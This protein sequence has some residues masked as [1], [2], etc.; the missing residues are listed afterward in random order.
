MLAG[1]TDYG[2]DRETAGPPVT[3]AQAVDGLIRSLTTAA[4]LGEV[5]LEF[6]HG[7]LRRTSAGLVVRSGG[8][9]SAFPFLRGSGQP[10]GS[11]PTSTTA[12]NAMVL[13]SRR[14]GRWSTPSSPRN[15]RTAASSGPSSPG[16]SWIIRTGRWSHPSAQGGGTPVAE[17]LIW[18]SPSLAYARADKQMDTT[19][20]VRAV[21]GPDRR[22][23]DADD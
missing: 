6:V 23:A 15:R 8:A 9:V 10:Y 11:S 7:P 20:V 3:Q 22:S 13:G 1:R 21:G 5:G 17:W 14:N 4:A 2:V 18:A 19:A 16:P 12:R